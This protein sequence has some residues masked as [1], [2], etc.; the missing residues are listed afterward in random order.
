MKL[1]KKSPSPPHLELPPHP[2]QDFSKPPSP[3]R[4]RVILEHTF[5]V[6]VRNQVADF[7]VALTSAS[8]LLQP[9][10][11][12]TVKSSACCK[13]CSN[14]SCIE[15]DGRDIVSCRPAHGIPMN[16]KFD[17]G[18]PM[19]MLVTYPSWAPKN[20]P[21]V[22]MYFH[23][24]RERMGIPPQQIL[25]ENGNNDLVKI[26]KIKDEWVK[27]IHSMFFPNHT[28]PLSVSGSVRKLS[29]TNAFLSNK[30]LVMLNPVAGSGQALKVF[31][32]KIIPV[33]RDA[34]TEYEVLVTE[35]S[36]HAY[37]LVR[38]ENL[39]RWKAIL[40]VSGDG[41][42]QEVFNGLFDRADWQDSLAHLAVGA[43]PVG[44]KNA[45]ARSM[46]HSQGEGTAAAP[47]SSSSSDSV[48]SNILNAARCQLNP[49]DLIFVQ[50]KNSAKVAILNLSWGILNNI[51]QAAKNNRTMKLLG[52]SRFSFARLMH[53][54]SMKTSSAVLSYLPVVSESGCSKKRARKSSKL[55]GMTPNEFRADS[56]SPTQSECSSQHSSGEDDQ[57][58]KRNSPSTQSKPPRFSSSSASKSGGVDYSS[59]RT[60]S[61]SC[62][63]CS[64]CSLTDRDHLYS[65]GGG[66]SSSSNSAQTSFSN[67]KKNEKN[68]ENSLEHL[69]P[70]KQR[71]KGK[72]PD[73]SGSRSNN[74]NNHDQLHT[75]QSGPSPVAPPAAT[76]RYNYTSLL[77]EG[78]L[79]F[80]SWQ[81][82]DVRLRHTGPFP[83]LNNLP[84]IMKSSLSK[85]QQQREQQQHAPPSLS[86]FQGKRPKPY[87]P[88]MPEIPKPLPKEAGW[89]T[90]VGDF[91]AIHLLNQAYLDKSKLLAPECRHDDGTLWLLLVRAG[92][93]RRDL[94]RFLKSMET[95]GTVHK[96]SGVE[97]I[98][99]RG[100]RLAPLT[101]ESVLTVDGEV[102][103]CDCIQ[104][105]IMPGVARTMIK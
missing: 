45:F 43:V 75:A 95:G 18:P 50:T 72:H 56:Q 25:D 47:D 64:T 86:S 32:E 105:F 102:V 11:P 78:Q 44:D 33:F 13:F 49:L 97:L 104:A 8:I 6:W 19:F 91:I 94:L 14:L 9:I 100:L 84:G 63:T 21:R 39:A 12:S 99:V 23:W 27:A 57:C 70:K 59:S 7:E 81:E 55:V 3:R 67:P 87:F 38:V 83:I 68:G 82:L 34:G 37:E 17:M 28:G 24:V 53:V 46:M 20:A 30:I 1:K 26:L 92:I 51:H 103:E 29:F 41:L 101:A 58:L 88:S 54:T 85:Q 66:V 2:T 98:P 62:Y 77:T 89:V 60:S 65:K 69:I 48:M 36:M 31:K 80:R 71:N 96:A 93:S 4:R 5:R 76:S 52:Q 15:V 10:A 40:V 79:Y 73:R 35:Y 42:L 74:N 16:T 90:E 22:V 61:S